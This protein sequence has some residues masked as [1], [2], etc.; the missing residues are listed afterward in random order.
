[1][2]SALTIVLL[3]FVSF[4]QAQPLELNVWPDGAP[5]NEELA[6]AQ[7]DLNSKYSDDNLEAKIFVYLPESQTA[8]SA[9]LICPGGSYGRLAISYEGHEV[10]QWL[11]GQGIA[12]IVMK[13]RLPHGIH[14]I[15]IAD[16]QQALRVIRKNASKWNIDPSKVGVAGLSAGG[17]LASTVATH[18][19]DS[20]T[21]PDFAVLF[22][23]VVST[24]STITHQASIRN[25]LGKNPGDELLKL[26]S[27]ELQVTGQTPPTLLFHSD[28]DSVVPAENSVEFYLSLKANKVPASMYIFP[29]GGHGWGMKATYAYHEKWKELMLTWLKGINMY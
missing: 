2:K 1:M 9:V 21:R 17:H 6:Q 19:R 29:N 13:Y 22:Y 23:P 4:L 3:F 10:A 25:L 27:N 20:L 8:T 12:G 26:Y 7:I 24:D 14:Q 18:F 16:A 11:S 5:Y 15:P 28:N